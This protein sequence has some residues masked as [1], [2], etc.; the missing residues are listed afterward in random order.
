MAA[1]ETEAMEKAR[2]LVLDGMTPYAASLAVGISKQAIYMS[3]WYRAWKGLPPR[4]KQG[5]EPPAPPKEAKKQRA[6]MNRLT[7]VWRSSENAKKPNNAKVSGTKK[8]V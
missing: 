5:E 4:N 3:P 2:K 8:R 6:A 1:R 7:E